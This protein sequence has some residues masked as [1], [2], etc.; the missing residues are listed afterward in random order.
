MSRATQAWIVGTHDC[1]NPV[2]HA[3]RKL[4][5]VDVVLSHLLHAAAN[6]EVVVTGGDDQVRPCDGALFV[7]FVVMDQSST[8]SLDHSDTFESV[9]SSGGPHV[10]IENASIGQ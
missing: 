2:Q 5:A 1:R 8:R 3:L 10:S 9:D 6:R 7:H 4:V